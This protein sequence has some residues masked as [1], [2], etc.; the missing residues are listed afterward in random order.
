[1]KYIKFAI[2]GA[3]LALATGGLQHGQMHLYDGSVPHVHENGV[4]HAH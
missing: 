1:M 3:F 2:L 4:I